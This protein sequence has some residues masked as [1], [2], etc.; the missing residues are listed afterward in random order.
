[1]RRVTPNKQTK[2]TVSADLLSFISSTGS[3]YPFNDG[4]LLQF[5]IF[6]NC[7]FIYD[8]SMGWRMGGG[9]VVLFLSRIF[10]FY[11]DSTIV[12]KGPLDFCKEGSL[13]LLYY[14]LKLK[15]KEYI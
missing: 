15:Q 2:K 4:S 10:L 11:G 5:T 3:V 1:M 9:S 13:Y 12:G 7:D 14:H 6:F 8:I